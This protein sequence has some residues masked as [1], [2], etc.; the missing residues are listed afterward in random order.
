MRQETERRGLE[1]Y[2]GLPYPVTIHLDSEGGFVAE[3]EELSGCM[4]QAENVEDSLRAIEDARTLWIK[5]AYSEGREIPLP[6][7]LEEYTGKFLVRIPKSL[8]KALVRVA[9]HEGI[10]L[11]QYVST[12]LASGIKTNAFTTQIDSHYFGLL[13]P[14]GKNGL[15]LRRDQMLNMKRA[16]L[17]SRQ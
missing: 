1:Y 4:T 15:P 3:I 7:D 9:K 16:R 11:N 13:P 6:R 2:L 12:L 10:S 8:H 5:A 17:V 14:F